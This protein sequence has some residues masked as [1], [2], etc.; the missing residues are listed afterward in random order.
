MAA[1]LLC[2]IALSACKEQPAAEP[3][4]HYAVMT[5]DTASV[6][7]ADSYPATL[8][9]RHDVDIYPQV[10]GKISQVCVHEG[11]RVRQGQTLFV[12][13]QTGYVAAL[14]TAEANLAAARASLAT[15][16]LDYEGTGRLYEGR[17]VSAHELKTKK[18]ALLAAKANVKQGEAQVRLAQN[19]L[20]YTV[21]KSPTDGVVGTIPY[22][23]GAYVSPSLAS[24][25]TTVSDN[26][27][28][29]VYF[30]LPE[31]R[32]LSI[33]RQYGSPE[34]VLKA[35]PNVRLR[36]SDGSIYGHGGR[37]ESISGVLNPQTGSMQLRAVFPNA[38]GLLHSGGAGD[39][40]LD[41]HRPRVL[42][43]PQ[44]ATFE[45]Q[46]K[47]FVYRVEGGKAVSTP[48]SVQ[49]IDGQRYEVTSGLRRG[50]V[51]VASGVATLQDGTAIDSSIK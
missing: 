26:A 31:T 14:Q 22:R 41:S 13:D 2:A 38:D 5:V 50:D 35:M 51:I 18:N 48:V 23:S 29:Y 27:A 8:T 9:G 46:D 49:A 42:V 4:P 36:L 15:A 25:L 10:D 44:S 45:I 47:V 24:P 28:M 11:Q 39:I 34:R 32:I 19:N 20:S 40:I 7:V 37:I 1:S 21:V 3:R 33:L 12:V 30:S 17:V 16:N 6:S 43:I